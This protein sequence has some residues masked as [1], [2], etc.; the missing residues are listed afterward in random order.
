VGWEKGLSVR[1]TGSTGEG[2]GWVR[3]CQLGVGFGRMEE[4]SE[5]GD[6]VV[7]HGKSKPF[8]TGSGKVGQGV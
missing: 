8:L 1:I 4:E 6:V 5:R 7:G 2:W 3:A